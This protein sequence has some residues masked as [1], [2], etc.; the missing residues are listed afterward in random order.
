MKRDMETGKATKQNRREKDFKMV[1]GVRIAA[2][3]P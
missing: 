3:T 2:E 1:A